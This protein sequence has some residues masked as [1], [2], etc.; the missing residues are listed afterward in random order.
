MKSSEGRHYHK[1]SQEGEVQVGRQF[2]SILVTFW[3]PGVLLGPFGGSPGPRPHFLINFGVIL[4]GYGGIQGS[5]GAPCGPHWAP[6]CH[7]CPYFWDL[8]DDLGAEPCFCPVLDSK[9]E[10]KR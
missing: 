4:E 5:L 3:S 10:R 8:F 9:K 1:F 6:L 2:P 7:Q